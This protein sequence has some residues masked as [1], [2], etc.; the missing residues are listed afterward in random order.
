MLQLFLFIISEHWR[1]GEARLF[2]MLTL[3]CTSYQTWGNS[4]IVCF[5]WALAHG[6]FLT[7]TRGCRILTYLC[8][9]QMMTHSSC[10]WSVNQSVSSL[11]HSFSP[12]FQPC[13]QSF[14][15]LNKI[16]INKKNILSLH[17]LTTSLCPQWV[18]WPEPHG[19]VVYFDTFTHN[20]TAAENIRQ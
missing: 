18:C 20:V 11:R 8:I 13:F 14:H 9:W 17:H 7:H 19:A 15:Q 1:P 4:A 2:K 6:D 12:R 10:S 3:F 5:L 16:Q